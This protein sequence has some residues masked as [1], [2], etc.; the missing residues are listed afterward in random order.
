MLIIGDEV[1]IINLF[2]IL[3]DFEDVFT[4][5]GFGGRV[6][7]MKQTLLTICL[8]LFSLPSW[9]ETIKYDDLVERNGLYYK[10]C[11]F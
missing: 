11:F 5:D 10:K 8:I 3:E 1:D 6:L 2:P 4:V 7:G 9:G